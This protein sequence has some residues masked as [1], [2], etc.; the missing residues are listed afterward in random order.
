VF[1]HSSRETSGGQIVLPSE[2]IGVDIEL[3]FAELFR[4]PL[5]LQIRRVGRVWSG[6]LWSR[7][8]QKVPERHRQQMSD[9]TDVP[10]SGSAGQEGTDDFLAVCPTA[11][12][13]H[14]GVIAERTAIT[15]GFEYSCP[16]RHPADF[17]QQPDPGVSFG[18]I[19]GT[20]QLAPEREDSAQVSVSHSIAGNVQDLAWVDVSSPAEIGG[21]VEE[22]NRLPDPAGAGQNDKGVVHWCAG[23]VGQGVCPV[24]EI[25]GAAILQ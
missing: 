13:G 18:R 22:R 17:V 11:T 10:C 20:G 6:E 21:G 24:P 16:S 9:S 8:S 3:H 15:S 1:G 5:G 7:G 2:V 4:R 12:G 14:D 25:V 19:D 23:N